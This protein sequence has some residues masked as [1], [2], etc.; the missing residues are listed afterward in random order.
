MTA[1]RSWV[2]LTEIDSSSTAM[3]LKIVGCAD[4]SGTRFLDAG[5][6]PEDEAW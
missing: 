5:C 1:L 6:L 3:K 2:V 4:V